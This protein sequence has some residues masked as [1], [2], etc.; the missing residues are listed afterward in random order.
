M[1]PGGETPLPAARCLHLE[2]KLSSQKAEI[3][4]QEADLEALRQENARL[5]GALESEHGGE[6][7]VLLRELDHAREQ[8]D[9]LQA[10]HARLE[11]LWSESK[12][13]A[14]KLNAQW[15]VMAEALGLDPTLGIG[16]IQRA[17]GALVS[18]ADALQADA[19]RLAAALKWYASDDE[20]GATARAALTAHEESKA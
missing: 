14:A 10:E 5:R 15:S 9:A 2:R 7:E 13:G 6:P 8:R 16:Q 19:D 12:E 11:R 3:R 20:D 1:S 17:A 18:H 4:R